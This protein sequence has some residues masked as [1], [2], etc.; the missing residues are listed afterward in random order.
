MIWTQEEVKAWLPIL[1]AFAD[2]EVI[3]RHNGVLIS[4]GD[5][6]EPDPEGWKDC[7]SRY[8]DFGMCGLNHK[9]IKNPEGYYRLKPLANPCI[10]CKY[11]SN[12]FKKGVSAVSPYITRV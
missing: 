2:G 5:C 7:D 12:G 11:G 1:Q 3:Q 8:I 4:N 6:I 9:Y 10:G